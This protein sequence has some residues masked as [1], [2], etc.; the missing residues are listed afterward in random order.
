MLFAVTRTKPSP[1]GKVAA[2]GVYAFM[3]DLSVITDDG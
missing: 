3:T 2:V 1:Q